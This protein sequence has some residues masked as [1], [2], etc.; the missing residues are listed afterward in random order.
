MNYT[1]TKPCNNCPFLRSGGIRLHPERV[2]EIAG[3]MLD[4]Q[5]IQFPCHKSVE[6]SDDDDGENHI[7]QAD[8]V[9]CAGALIFA[10]KNNTATQMMRI[11]QRLRMY[12]P[13]TLM[14][15]PLV[16]NS[17]FNDVDEMAETNE[18]EQKPKKERRKAARR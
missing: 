10:E 18:R 14:A 16:V 9:H 7:P 2:E 12:D 17:V 5:G 11:A 6:H 4:S 3:G 15:N 8:E 1:M 13:R